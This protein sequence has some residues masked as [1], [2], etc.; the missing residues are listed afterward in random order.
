MKATWKARE[1]KRAETGELKFTN[2]QVEQIRAQAIRRSPKPAGK[3]LTIRLYNYADAPAEKLL[4]AAAVGRKIF[5]RAGIE[6]AWVR[7]GTSSE[8]PSEPGC[9]EARGKSV[10][11]VNVLTKTMAE[12]AGTSPGAFGVAL[13]AKPGFGRVAAVFHHRISELHRDSR[14]DAPLILGHILAH[15][16]GH[17]MLGFNSHTER[18]IMAGNWDEDEMLMMKQ[19]SIRFHEVQARRMR[20]QVEARMKADG[21]G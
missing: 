15:E 8:R 1:L 3:A 7:C 6:T 16:I 4:E 9:I 19:G 10:I 14:V 17:L 18:G 20:Q 12:K 5:E 2:K 11:R 13:T 21:R